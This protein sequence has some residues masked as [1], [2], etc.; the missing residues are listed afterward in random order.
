M[1]T[2]SGSRT[3]YIF[4]QVAA[5]IG[6]S[7]NLVECLETMVNARI[8][9]TRDPKLENTAGIAFFNLAKYIDRNGPTEHRHAA[10]QSL[11]YALNHLNRTGTNFRII[12]VTSEDIIDYANDPNSKVSLKDVTIEATA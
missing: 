5:E 1:F 9:E 8:N 12:G 7:D 10:A 3:N 4:A 11:I 2:G 6:D